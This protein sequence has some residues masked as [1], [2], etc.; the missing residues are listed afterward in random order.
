MYL[1]TGLG[2]HLQYLAAVRAMLV[3][4]HGPGRA[5]YRDLES[6]ST[7]QHIAQMGTHEPNQK[8]EKDYVA[9]HFEEEA[10]HS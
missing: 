8:W 2:L 4:S 9:M 7:Q 6:V 5:A 3:P 1:L 10:E